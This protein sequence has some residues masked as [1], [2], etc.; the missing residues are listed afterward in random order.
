MS[1]RL[2][3]DL[4]VSGV[5]ASPNGRQRIIGGKRKVRLPPGVTSGRPAI[6]RYG[7][8]PT[9]AGPSTLCQTL[10]S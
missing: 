5:L 10:I 9:E 4:V 7:N 1:L 8:G 6:V 3:I 2:W